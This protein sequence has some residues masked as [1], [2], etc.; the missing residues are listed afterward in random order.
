MGLGDILDDAVKGMADAAQQQGGGLLGEDG[1]LHCPKCGGPKQM[2]LETT[3]RDTPL[4]VPIQCDC[5]LEAER[6]REEAERRAAQKAR[7]ARARAECFKD[8][9]FLLGCTFEGDDGL[10]PALS[11]A[12]QRYAETF[13]G[14]DRYG[15][16]LWGDVGTGKSFM[17]AAIANRVIDLG[18]TALQTDIGSIV[19]ARESSFEDRKRNLD[20]LMGYDLLL[21]DDLGAQRST[22]YLME[23]VYAVVDGR[24]RA[25]KPM[26]ITTNMDAG[27][28]ADRR[29]SGPWSR[30]IDR[31]LEV[32]YPLEFKGKS[33]R[34]S[35]AFDMRD[36][37]KKRLGL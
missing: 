27:L 22:E 7:A 17:S 5:E 11:S 3:L 18:F 32:C 8:C 23:Q 16:L 1:L 31:I 12:C 30:V 26:V 29:D 10:R 28:I 35:N 4:I 6:E 9:G 14:K 33:R 21:I 20:R 25:G 13:D 24:Y 2:R 19:T 37:M 15:L 34:R 36:A